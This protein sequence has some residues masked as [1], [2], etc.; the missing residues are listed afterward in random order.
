[1][2]E[3]RGGG[4]NQRQI[5]A[6]KVARVAFAHKS[7][8]PVP[9]PSLSQLPS[10]SLSVSCSS[11][12]RLRPGCALDQMVWSVEQPRAVKISL[13]IGTEEASVQMQRSNV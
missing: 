11:S 1:M 3:G 8:C 10:P 4:I 12:C 9:F 2:K 13:S 6:N 5:G 7:H